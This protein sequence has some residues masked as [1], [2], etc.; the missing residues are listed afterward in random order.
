LHGQGH[1]SRHARKQDMSHRN[2]SSWIV[3]MILECSGFAV[4]YWA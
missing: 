3:G 1:G 4:S 2:P